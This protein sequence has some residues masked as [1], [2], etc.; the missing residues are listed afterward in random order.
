MGRSGKSH[1]S[2]RMWPQIVAKRGLA[3]TALGEHRPNRHGATRRSPWHSEAT[4]PTISLVLEI[5][6][7][8]APSNRGSHDH[9]RALMEVASNDSKDD[10]HRRAT[11]DVLPQR[12]MLSTTSLHR[13]VVDIVV[14]IPLEDKAQKSDGGSTWASKSNRLAS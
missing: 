3:R 2:G 14:D 5:R 13:R 6:T 9:V 11:A 4:P 12:R 1:Q 7:W 10:D 8:G